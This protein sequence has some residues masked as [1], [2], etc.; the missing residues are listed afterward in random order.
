MLC[1]IC[2]CS[3]PYSTN[4]A[5]DKNSSQG[6]FKS[7]K[8]QNVAQIYPFALFVLTPYVQSGI[9]HWDCVSTIFVIALVLTQLLLLVTKTR[10]KVCFLPK[11]PIKYV[12]LV[13][14]ATYL[15]VEELFTGMTCSTISVTGLVFTQLLVLVTKNQGLSLSPR[16]RFEFEAKM[17]HTDDLATYLAEEPLT[18]IQSQTFSICREL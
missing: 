6:F 5:G 4:L 13:E 11:C 15:A 14:I 7:T 16:S 8:A 2:H 12:P 3:A 1:Y 10:V 18:T 9:V 17:S